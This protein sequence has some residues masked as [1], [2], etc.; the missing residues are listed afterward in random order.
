M[1]ATVNQ[2]FFLSRNIAEVTPKI[3]YFHYLKKRFLDQSIQNTIYLS[4]KIEAL[5]SMT[6]HWQYLSFQPLIE[7]V[8]SVNC[9]KK[10]QLWWLDIRR[11]QCPPILQFV[12]ANFRFRNASDCYGQWFCFQNWIKCFWDT[13]TLYTLFWIMK[14]HS[15][16]GDLV[17]VSAKTKSLVK[18]GVAHSASFLAE[19]LVM[20]P[21][22]LFIF[23]I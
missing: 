21:R 14:T 3:M 5:Q 4:L 19:T 13:L 17:D 12:Y 15:F 23:I 18:S 16:Q 22:K 9:R 20:S 2:C 11:S 8:R 1:S 7:L 10:I 6:C